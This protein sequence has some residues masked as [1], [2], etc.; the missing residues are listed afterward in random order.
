MATLFNT[1]ERIVPTWMA[2]AKHLNN[3]PRRQARNLLLEISNPLLLTAADNEIL[4]RVDEA[5]S[6]RGLT[7]RTVAGTIFP[8]DF[9]R[10]FKR[11]AFYHEYLSMLQRGKKTGSWGTYAAR[12]IDRE[13][14]RDGERINPL[15]ML[16]QRL[17]DSGQPKKK[18]GGKI[19]YPS[20]YELGVSDPYEDLVSFEDV[21]GE[22]PTYN[23]A[24]DGRQWLGMPCLSHLSFKRVAIE[25]GYAVDLTAIYRSHHYCARA[26]GNLIGLGQLLSFVATESGLSVGSLSCLSTHAELDVG[27]WGGVAASNAILCPSE[28]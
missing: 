21:G 22:V 6:P 17:S 14:K 1:H 9:Y 11:P 3:A 20:A 15:E 5:L 2:A 24:F 28:A 23:C 12:M 7:L 25:D 26:L 10:R 18:N 8:L 16:V 4:T 27:K 13:G 19:S